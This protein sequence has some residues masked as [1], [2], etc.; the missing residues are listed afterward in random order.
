[1]LMTS[2]LIGK[3]AE[4]PSPLG[5]GMDAVNSAVKKKDI[6]LITA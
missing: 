3:Q 5:E 4:D 2:H 6:Y 1:M